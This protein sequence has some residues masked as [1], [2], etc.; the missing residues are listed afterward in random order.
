LKKINKNDELM[1]FV[2]YF[3]YFDFFFKKDFK[4]F[5]SYILFHFYSSICE[6]ISSLGLLSYVGGL[7]SY[8]LSVSFS[9]F[10][11]SLTTHGSLS[12]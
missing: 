1:T 3:C 4:F 12:T 5:G 11:A 6:F 10:P 9:V 7:L 2:I 8:D